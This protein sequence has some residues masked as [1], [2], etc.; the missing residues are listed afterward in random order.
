MSE[1]LGKWLSRI[2]LAVHVEDQSLDPLNPGKG[3]CG[4]THLTSAP[5]VRWETRQQKS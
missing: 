4:C 2:T 5:T 3:R 1:W